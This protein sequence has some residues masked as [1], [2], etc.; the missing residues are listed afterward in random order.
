[1]M[2]K[3]KAYQVWALVTLVMLSFIFLSGCAQAQPERYSLASYAMSTIVEQKAY[4]RNAQEAMQAVES[5]FADFENR[6]SLYREDSEICAINAAAGQEPIAVSADTFALLKQAKELS[7]ASD[8]AFALT[9]APLSLAWGITSDTPRVL[10]QEEIDALLPLV[11]DKDILLEEDGHTVLLRRAGQAL[12][13]GGVAKGTACNVAREL[14]A[15]YGVDSA[16]L[17][18]GG[19][20]YVRGVKP[21]GSRYRIG[22][23]DPTSDASASIAS[24]T[25]Q[26]AV[27]A[28]SGG[29]ERYFEQDGVRYIHIFDPKTGAPAKSDIVSVGVIDTDGTVADFY[30]T[31]L[32]VWGKEKALA[33]LSSEKNGMLLDQENH[34]YVSKALQDSFELSEDGYEVI[35]I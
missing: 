25:M 6:L 24:I 26:D 21:D 19:N 30:S 18:I 11:D 13:L 9:I 33:F 5:A 32:Y 20:V 2:Q 1:M 29:Y 31:T 34:L 28:V 3:T 7:L 27:F 15:K 22:F 12:D 10:S 23:R 4:G 14:Y 8:N 16:V 17:S 35:F